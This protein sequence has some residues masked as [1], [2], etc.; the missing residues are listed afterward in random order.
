MTDELDGIEDENIR[1]LIRQARE[2]KK[3]IATER[4]ALNA[5][6]RAVLFDRLGVPDSGPGL[7]F[8]ETYNGEITAEAV[9]SAADR[10]GVLAPPPQQSY[11]QQQQF[12][13]QDADLE[14]MRTMQSQVGGLGASPR[15]EDEIYA[16]L[17]ATDGEPN[18]VAAIVREYGLKLNTSDVASA[19]QA[20]GASL[21][22]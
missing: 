10:Y 4:E 18:A 19:P 3:T 15:V 2:D 1:N 12:S 22:S 16:K 17:M 21:N 14:R 13:Q 6:K 8:R 7:M 5:E 11:Q 20:W 9:K